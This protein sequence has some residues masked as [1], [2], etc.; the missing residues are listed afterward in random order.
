MAS[1]EDILQQKILTALTDP[2]NNKVDEYPEIMPECADFFLSQISTNPYDEVNILFKEFFTRGYHDPLLGLT[3]SNEEKKKILDAIL[4][5]S[6][7]TGSS[8]PIIYSV[9][10]EGGRLGC[11]L[12][13]SCLTL[14]GDRRIK[15]IQNPPP[16]SIIRLLQP[17][18][19]W[20]FFVERM[21]TFKMLGALLDDYATNGRYPIRS[22]RFVTHILEMMIRHVK[23]GNSSSIRDRA[24]TYARCLGWGVPNQT[25]KVDTSKVLNNSAFNTLFHE[26][27]VHS[28]A[29]F[30]QKRLAEAIQ[31]AVVTPPSLATV[32][33]IRDT[34]S[35]LQ[36]AMDAFLYGRNYYNTL[37]GIVWAI[38]TVEVVRRLRDTIGIPIGFDRLD[39]IIPA[40][41]NILVEK[42]SINLTEPNRF[43][44]HMQCANDARDIL[45]DIAGNAIDFTNEADLKTWLNVI[46]PRVEGYRAA[47][48]DLTGID[49]AK[50]EFRSKGILRVEQQI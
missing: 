15:K 24:S 16:K 36:D 4:C 46:E 40:A 31:T 47:Y 23:M 45:I 17:D 35:L 29:Y 42:K 37:N 9:A 39:Q 1:P 48:L 20:L 30:Q 34:I 7:S 12:P 11:C 6:K 25:F 3:D 28:L 43:K 13:C 18:L 26:V 8:D 50:P 21:G 5:R 32:I 49:L 41:Y 14:K 19:V 33:A 38:A 27:M 10:K 44:L 22:D 2:A